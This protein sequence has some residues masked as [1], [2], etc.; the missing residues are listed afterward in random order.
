ML[1]FVAELSDKHRSESG[2]L[3][4][5]ISV[6]FYLWLFCYPANHGNKRTSEQYINQQHT[7]GERQQ[8]VRKCMTKMDLVNIGKH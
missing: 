2:D 1:P 3:H 4:F 8:L 7:Q 5:S 6:D